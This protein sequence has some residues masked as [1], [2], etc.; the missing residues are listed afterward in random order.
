M[1]AASEVEEGSGGGGEV[2]SAVQNADPAAQLRLQ[3]ADL[4]AASSGFLGQ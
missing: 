3:R 2:C 1:L 4:R